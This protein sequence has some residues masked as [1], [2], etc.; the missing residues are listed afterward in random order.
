MRFYNF[1]RLILGDCL[2]NLRCLLTLLKGPVLWFICCTAD[3]NIECIDYSLLV[4]FVLSINKN[5]F[6]K[7]GEWNCFFPVTTHLL[8]IK[9]QK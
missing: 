6:I 7:S 4:I 8:N 5:S 3:T 2:E 9:I 1:W